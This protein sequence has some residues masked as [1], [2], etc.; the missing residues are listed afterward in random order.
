MAPCT[1]Q[2][3]IGVVKNQT[4]IGI[5][6]V[7]SN[8]ASE[9][10]V[11]IVKATSHDDDPASEKYIQ[12]ILHLSSSSRGYV[13]ACVSSISKRLGKTRDWIVAIKCLMLIHRLLN[14]GDPI[15]HQ[16]IMYATRRALDFL[17]CLIFAIRLILIR[18][19]IR[20]LLEL[21]LCI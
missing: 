21:M 5:A 3:A 9:L 14:D 16:E 6:K 2:K 10:E 12:E 18:R 13:T 8:L 4:S 17:I 7:G 1:I 20:P 19:I 11:A 15:F